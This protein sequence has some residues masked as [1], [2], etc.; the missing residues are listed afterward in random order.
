MP[1]YEYECKNCGQRFDKLQPVT[2]ESLTECILCGKGPIRRVIQAV[3]VI[4]K[5]SGWYAT[6]NRNANKPKASK[7]SDSGKS[8]EGSSEPAAKPA[9]GSGEKSAK[10]DT[11]TKE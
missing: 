4:F 7:E 3:G 5:G 11:A 2:S 9:E 1:I 8:S 6:D 10:S